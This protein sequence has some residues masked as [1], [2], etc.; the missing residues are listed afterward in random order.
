MTSL[1]PET[2]FAD[3]ERLDIRVGR[4]RAVEDFPEARKPLYRVSVDFGQEVG[5]KQSGAGLREI[6]TKEQLVGS[7]V[8][9]VVN[10]PPRQ[11]GKFQSE[12][13]IL[14]AP[15]GDGDLALLLPEKEV[16]LGTKIF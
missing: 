6:R 16:P 15:I 12:C 9:A 8:V 10:F 4:I 11:I 13:L 5:V 7:L 1:L 3:F 14:A 2:S